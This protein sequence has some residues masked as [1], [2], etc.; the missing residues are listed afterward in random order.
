ME[1]TGNKHERSRGFDIRGQWIRLLER[2]LRDPVPAFGATE[3]V[4]DKKE[5]VEVFVDS[6]ALSGK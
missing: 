4:R 6:S 2:S 3:F 5:L 1:S